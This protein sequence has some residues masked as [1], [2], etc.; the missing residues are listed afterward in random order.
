[1]FQVGR[2]RTLTYEV[3]ILDGTWLDN[4]LIRDYFQADKPYTNIEVYIAVICVE[5]INAFAIIWNILALVVLLQASFRRRA[6]NNYLSF[7]C[8]VFLLDSTHRIIF[9]TI[10]TI[11]VSVLGAI[12]Y[13]CSVREEV[14]FVLQTLVAMLVTTI[15]VERY[16]AVAHPFSR[17]ADISSKTVK[18]VG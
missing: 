12:P 4:F 3:W 13:F 9:E 11:D 6:V 16:I 8:T 18:K 1:M 14:Y 2:A 5:F 10:E 7:L 15:S 17:M